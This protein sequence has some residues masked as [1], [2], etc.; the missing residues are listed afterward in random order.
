M[1]L[2]RVPEPALLN[3]AM[4]EN[5]LHP[6]TP[7][8]RGVDEDTFLSTGP[9]IGRHIVV[10]ARCRGEER[11]PSAGAVPSRPTLNIPMMPAQASDGRPHSISMAKSPRPDPNRPMKIFAGSQCGFFFWFFAYRSREAGGNPTVLKCRISSLCTL[12]S[13]PAAANG[14][15]ILSKAPR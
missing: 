9:P 10:E 5:R 2:Y 6:P 8:W 14:A 1:L 11:H 15:P 13:G 12:Y 4:V 3:P 7:P